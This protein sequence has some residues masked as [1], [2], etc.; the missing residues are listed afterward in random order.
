MSENDTPLSHLIRVDDIE[1]TGSDVVLVPTEQERTAIAAFLKIPA[2]LGM[3]AQMH[4]V[5]GGS[6]VTVTGRLTAQVRQVCVVSLDEFESP[7]DEP[8]EIIFDKNAPDP[9]DP[10]ALKDDAPDPIIGGVIDLGQVAVEF[11]AL[12]LD[13]YPRKPG[14]VFEYREDDGGEES[15]FAKLVKLTA[16]P[17]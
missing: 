10:A 8:I 4:L 9:S 14:A 2:V 13:P 17:E 7:V 3:K 6:R 11:L 16:K 15:P 5:R 12:G 1:D